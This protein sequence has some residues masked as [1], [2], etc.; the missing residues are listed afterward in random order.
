MKI[1]DGHGWRLATG[2]LA[3]AVIIGSFLLLSIVQRLSETGKRSLSF[4]VSRTREF[5]RISSTSNESLSFQRDIYPIFEKSCFFCHGPKR[6]IAGFRA[7]RLSDFFRDDGKG[8]LVLPG[9][10]GQSRLLA[11]VSGAKKM[12]RNVPDHILSVEEVALIKSWIDAGAQ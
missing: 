7:D 3:G 11:I 6:H 4:P 8:P 2:M 5:I 10:S 1:N 9:N 12:K